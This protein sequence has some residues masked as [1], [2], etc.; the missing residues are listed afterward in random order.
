MCLCG[1]CRGAERGTSTGNWLGVKKG[2]QAMAYRV[3]R[4][5][6]EGYDQPTDDVAETC[7]CIE[8]MTSMSASS[9]TCSA[10]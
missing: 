5:F 9:Q 7:T 4:C 10:S 1:A 6:Q 8:S 3:G 2:L